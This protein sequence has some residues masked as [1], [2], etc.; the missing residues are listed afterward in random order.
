[1]KQWEYSMIGNPDSQT[2]VQA[3]TEQGLDGWEAIT[4]TFQSTGKERVPASLL[5]GTMELPTA[6]M[7]VAI[8]KREIEPE[9]ASEAEG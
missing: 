9:E 6:P 8:M 3:L 7:W 4:A 1:M 5:G 2:F